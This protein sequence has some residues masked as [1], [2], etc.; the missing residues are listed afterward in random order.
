MDNTQTASMYRGRQGQGGR[1]LSAPDARSM[2]V[3]NKGGPATGTLSGVF[4]P[5]GM[6]IM[7][8]GNVTGG[9]G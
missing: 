7:V 4:S 2:E 1:H 6:T 9:V 3:I 8:D 5:G